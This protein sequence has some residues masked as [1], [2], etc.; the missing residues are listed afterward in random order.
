MFG[1]GLD[2]ETGYKRRLVRPLRVIMVGSH[3]FSERVP[4]ITATY[5][6]AS[7]FVRGGAGSRVLLFRIKKLRARFSRSVELLPLLHST[8]TK[9]I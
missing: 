4:L 7:S 3:V 8:S 2:I 1:L 5:F 9:T 6:M